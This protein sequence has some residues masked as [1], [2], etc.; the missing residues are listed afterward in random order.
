MPFGWDD[1]LIG[2]AS[3]LGGLGGMIGSN[4]AAKAQEEAAKHAQEAQRRNLM[5]Q[6]SINE[7]GR[8][9]GYNAMND[10]NAEFGYAPAQYTSAQQLNA[11][12][13]PLKSKQV[14]KALKNGMSFDQVYGMGSLKG[15]LDPK[16]VKRLTKA[17][18]SMDQIQQLSAGARTAGTPAMGAPGQQAPAGRGFM[19]SPDY[20]F[21]R[22]EGTRD[23]GSSFAARGGAASGNAMRA[24]SEFNSGLASSEYGNW[25]QRRAQLAGLGGQATANQSNAGNNYANGVGQAQMAQGDA[26]ASGIMGG[27]NSAV[28]AIN[29][30]LNNWMM[31]KY[32]NQ[33][34]G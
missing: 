21:R 11:M 6:T 28:G 5:Y 34:G 16:A 10:I 12:V 33:G 29:G 18:L 2:G 26:R 27:V 3:L 4:S 15:Q 32:M 14:A 1:A 7:P 19:A 8:F 31:M 13:T 23:I 20:Q 25:F 17:G 9:L 24:L 30:G 22:D